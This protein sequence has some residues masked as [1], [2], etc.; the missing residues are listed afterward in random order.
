MPKATPARLHGGRGR[1]ASSAAQSRPL[2]SKHD[3]DA[4]IDI[5][6]RRLRGES[7]SEMCQA[8]GMST[9]SVRRF[10]GLVRPDP[11]QKQATHDELQAKLERLQAI[12]EERFTDKKLAA[13]TGRPVAAVRPPGRASTGIA[14]GKAVASSSKRPMF[15]LVIPVK[16][17]AAPQKPVLAVQNARSAVKLAIVESDSESETESESE[18]SEEEEWELEEGKQE[19]LKLKDVELESASEL[20]VAEDEEG[21]EGAASIRDE[22]HLGNLLVIAY[23]SDRVVGPDAQLRKTRSGPCLLPTYEAL[24]E[25]R[26]D[27]S[28]SIRARG[29]SYLTFLQAVHDF[30]AAVQKRDDLSFLPTVVQLSPADR[31]RVLASSLLFRLY[32]FKAIDFIKVWNS[33]EEYEAAV[34]GALEK[35]GSLLLEF[36]LRYEEWADRWG[37]KA[38]EGV[39]SEGL[40]SLSGEARKRLERLGAQMRGRGC[41]AEEEAAIKGMEDWIDVC[42]GSAYGSGDNVK[43]WAHWIYWDRARR[44]VEGS[45]GPLTASAVS[46]VLAEKVGRTE[47][48]RKIKA[49]VME[50]WGLDSSDENGFGGFG[51][52]SLRH[53]L[54]LVDLFEV[55]ILSSFDGTVMAGLVNHGSKKG[56][57]S[58]V[59]E[60]E[61]RRSRRQGRIIRGGATSRTSSEHIP[62]FA[63]ILDRFQELAKPKSNCSA[64]ARELIKDGGLDTV[65][66]LEH[67][68]C[69]YS[70]MVVKSG[71]EGRRV[72]WDIRALGVAHEELYL[73]EMS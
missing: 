22:I 10:L 12:A 35:N 49:E 18:A 26:Q 61:S 47:E 64:R 17:K 73:V 51:Q 38:G 55:G 37:I 5:K 57:A 6:L 43:W 42:V 72:G 2:A 27:N 19:K 29:P 53:R 54:T 16:R 50:K 44:I 20:E 7:I 8:T 56:L 23:T 14:E 63:A 3:D 40:L 65:G 1:A 60:A 45:R 30:R 69:K 52:K 48:E 70:K 25:A 59:T 11:R 32:H 71:V 46:K 66:G 13:A 4:I 62:L 39:E 36:N 34:E 28:I 67:T 9:S 31:I 58:L 33:P 41:S 15:S 68:L 24:I 21:A